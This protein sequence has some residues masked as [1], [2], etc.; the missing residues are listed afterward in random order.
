MERKISFDPDLLLVAQALVHLEPQD[1]V[2]AVR[3][4]AAAAEAAVV[5]ILQIRRVLDPDEAV[6]M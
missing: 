1:Q 6:R 3:Q 2:R 4:A 5:A